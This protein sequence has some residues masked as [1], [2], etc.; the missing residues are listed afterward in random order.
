[1]SDSLV[2][3]NLPQHSR[4]TE[5][6]CCEC[7]VYEK[8]AMQHVEEARFTT[9]LINITHQDTRSSSLFL[10]KGLHSR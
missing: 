9:K 4:T 8:R 10:S 6:T 2:P 7:L 5:E 1:M 3:G